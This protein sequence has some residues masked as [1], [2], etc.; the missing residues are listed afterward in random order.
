MPK[1]DIL[2]VIQESKHETAVDKDSK[3]RERSISLQSTI[4]LIAPPYTV[5]REAIEALSTEFKYDEAPEF[6]KDLIQ[7][8]GDEIKLLYLSSLKGLAEYAESH[9][10][11]LY[12][13]V[14]NYTNKILSEDSIKNYIAKQ[15]EFYCTEYLEKDISLNKLKEF[16]SVQKGLLGKTLEVLLSKSNVETEFPS[17]KEMVKRIMRARDRLSPV[18]S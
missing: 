17:E 3:S 2:P 18:I 10:E 5:S 4:I 12:Y 1:T 9:T 16:N 7:G 6:K 8:K 11:K 13:F 15:K 14:Y